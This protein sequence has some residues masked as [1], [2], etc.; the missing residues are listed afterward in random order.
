MRVFSFR[1]TRNIAGNVTLRET[2]V[3]CVCVRA[4]KSR[5]LLFYI[6]PQSLLS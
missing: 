5:Y 4:P 3:V 1:C 6:L 2:L